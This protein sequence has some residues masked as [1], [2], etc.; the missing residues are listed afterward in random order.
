MRRDATASWNG[1]FRSRRCGDLLHTHDA[2]LQSAGTI[3]RE[4]YLREPDVFEWTLGNGMRVLLK[5]TRY[6]DSQILMRMTA[7]G[8]ASLADPASY[9]SAYL[10]DEV[11]Q[12]TGIGPLT[13]TDL[14]R[15]LETTTISLAPT[16]NDYGV[17]LSGS[18]GWAAVKMA[19]FGGRVIAS[20]TRLSSEQIEA[21]WKPIQPAIPL[22]SLAAQTK[23]RT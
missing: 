15:L 5:P 13:G 14:W 12:A 9:P 6:S 1:F 16:V 18:A 8:G 7:P 4:R 11:L 10:A 21:L 2:V 19:A 17:R 23:P 20:R 22:A 3:A